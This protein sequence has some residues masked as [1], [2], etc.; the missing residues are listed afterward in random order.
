MDVYSKLQSVIVL[1]TALLGVAVS[2]WP[3]NTFKIK[4]GLVFLF[5]V[6]GLAALFLQQQKE[7]GDV[8]KTETAQKELLN[9][10]RGDPNN[11]PRIGHPIVSVDGA[12]ITTMQFIVENPSQFPAYDIHGRLWDIDSLPQNPTRMEDILSHDIAQINESSLP[13]NTVK[14]INSIVVP[15]TVN[16]KN[17]G[18]QFTTRAGG[19]GEAM[20]A[21]K[22][23]GKWLFA[24]KVQRFGPSDEELYRRIDSGF[25]LNSKADVDW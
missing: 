23:N 13:G 7:K 2:L 10:Q 1:V 11:P 12:G 3:P 5:A 24:I 17:F 9:W 22:V 6:L 16:E 14:L 25:P 4:A 8:L 21:R 19:F 20:N 18:A 15:P